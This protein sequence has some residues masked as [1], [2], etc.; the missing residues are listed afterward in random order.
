MASKKTFGFFDSKKRISPQLKELLQDAGIISRFKTLK[1]YLDAHSIAYDPADLT[2]VCTMLEDEIYAQIYY[3]AHLRYYIY[4]LSGKWGDAGEQQIKIAFCRNLLQIPSSE[5]LS[6]EHVVQFAEKVNQTL[7]TLDIASLSLNEAYKRYEDFII[8]AFDSDF[9]LHPHMYITRWLR[10]MGS[11]K[12]LHAEPHLQNYAF[13]FGRA[14]YRQIKEFDVFF[15]QQE[16]IRTPNFVM[17]NAA[18]TRYSDIYIRN[19]SLEAIFY[20]KWVPAAEAG[21][22]PA[23]FDEFV[24][25]SNGIKR[26]VLTKYGVKGKE[27]LIAIKSQFI[28][29]MRETIVFHEIGHGALKDYILPAYNLAVGRGTANSPNTIYESLLEFLTDLTPLV[30]Q[31]RGPLMNMI[32]VAEKDAERAERMF[33]MYLSDTWFYDTGDMYMY[34]YSDLIV[35]ILLR[36]IKDDR[37]IDFKRMARDIRFSPDYAVKEKKTLFEMLVDQYVRDT[38]ELGQMIEQATF[39]FDDNKLTKDFQYM[40]KLRF[41]NAKAKNPRMEIDGYEFLA[42]F[43]FNVFEFL[44]CFSPQY[45]MV[46]EFLEKR[47]KAFV[48]NI[49]AIASDKSFAKLYKNNPRRF[50]TDRLT[51]LGFDAIEI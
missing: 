4:E 15:L 47:S 18:M 33:Y 28:A 38:S 20:Q 1:N 50:I 51:S 16:L 40:K 8:R 17:A 37:R 11:D 6:D 22:T 26:L 13:I 34:L 24:T 46:L 44:R 42:P 27:D 45:P 7:H 39:V 23:H 43:W 48:V 3:L 9:F 25:L 32:K 49:I 5:M 19:E 31:F 14:E 10:F 30:G 35:T 29:D 41:D 2:R 12:V 21:N 36:Y